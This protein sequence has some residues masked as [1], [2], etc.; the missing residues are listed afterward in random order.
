M[1]L[2][3]NLRRDDKPDSALVLVA[4]RQP[5]YFRCRKGRFIKDCPK[6]SRAKK[7]E[8][9]DVKPH[10]SNTKGLLTALAVNIK[11]ELWYIDSGATEH[12]CCNKDIMNNF[13]NDTC[14]QV[15]VANGRRCI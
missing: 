11:K 5:K 8:G 14:L 7:V 4:R 10:T 9:Q 6:S 13:V 15:K 1:L 3:E 2:Q 12:M